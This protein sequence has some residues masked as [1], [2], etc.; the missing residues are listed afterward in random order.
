MFRAM[1]EAEMVE[2]RTNCLEIEDMSEVGVKALLEFIY[3]WDLEEASKDCGIALELLK[4]GDK[5]QMEDL[6]DAMIKLICAMPFQWFSEDVAAE[7]KMYAGNV[8]GKLGKVEE[9]SLA[10]LNWYAD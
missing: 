9:K 7:I 1:F 6:E 10:V 5:Y 8:G 4:A 2:S 3:G